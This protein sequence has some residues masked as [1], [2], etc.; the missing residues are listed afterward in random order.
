MKLITNIEHGLTLLQDAF[1][2]TVV[3]RRY[4]CEG[5]VPCAKISGFA[6]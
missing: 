6:G 1:C 4:F 5:K 3:H 2:L